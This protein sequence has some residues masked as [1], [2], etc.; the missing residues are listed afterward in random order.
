M[1]RIEEKYFGRNVG[2]YFHP[3]L[4]YVLYIAFLIMSILLRVLPMDEVEIHLLFIPPTSIFVLWLT[5]QAKLNAF[6]DAS[7]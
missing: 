7:S 5:I 4:I 2:F 1:K 3:V 6:F